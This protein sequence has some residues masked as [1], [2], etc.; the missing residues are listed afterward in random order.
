[1]GMIWSLRVRSGLV[2]CQ[3]VRA[4]GENVAPCCRSLSWPKAARSTI[5]FLFFFGLWMVY[6]VSNF[7]VSHYESV[8]WDVEVNTKLLGPL[9]AC[10]GN[11]A[12]RRRVPVPLHRVY[13]IGYSPRHGMIFCMASFIAYCSHRESMSQNWLC[14]W[15]HQQKRG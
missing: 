12:S 6:G 10:K 9:W 2:H 5:F 4:S 8:G 15:T 7:D 14:W 13:E 11:V 1:M 3:L